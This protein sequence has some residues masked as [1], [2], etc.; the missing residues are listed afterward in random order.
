MAITPVEMISMAPKSQEAS[1]M[2]HNEVQKPTVEQQQIAAKMNSE[3]RHNS[4]Q[5][6]PT[7]KSLNPEFRYDAKE[8]GNNSYDG[9]GKKQKKKDSEKEKQQNAPS[10]GRI[11]IRL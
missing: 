10:F 7:N 5:A 4:N 2:K 8:K 9:K 3:I 6:V 11:D 1:F